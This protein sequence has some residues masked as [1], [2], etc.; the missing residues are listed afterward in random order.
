[1][2]DG[3]R[4]NDYGRGELRVGRD[5]DKPP[6]TEHGGRGHRLI[7]RLTPYNCY[8]LR[9]LKP[10]THNLPHSSAGVARNG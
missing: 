9:D 3:Q 1:M 7:D 8:D 2:A 6:L 5:K 10:A 4:I